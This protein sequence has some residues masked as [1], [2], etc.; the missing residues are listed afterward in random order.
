MTT[1]KKQTFSATLVNYLGIVLGFALILFVMPAIFNEEEV[2][3]LRFLID[4]HIIL[5]IVASLGMSNSLVRFYPS[6]L[7]NKNNS[8]SLFFSAFLI[9]LVGFIIT[10]LLFVLGQKQIVAFF[11][12]KSPALI[13]YSWF[14]LPMIFASMYFLLF[15]SILSIY[16]KVFIPK[17]LK[18]FVIRFLTLFLY[19]LYHW[20]LLT[21]K[22]SVYGLVIVYFI[23]LLFIA[24][25]SI[26]K[27]PFSF[28]NNFNF[29]KT[30]PKIFKEFFSFSFFITMGGIGGLIYAK[31]DLFMLAGYLGLD[32]V[33]IYGIAFYA[34]TII[35]IPKR[36]ITQSI[37]PSLSQF[38]NSHDIKSLSNA[39]KRVSNI[40]FSLGLIL[41]LGLVINIDNLYAIMPKGEIYVLG[42]SVVLVIAFTKAIE[43][44]FGSSLSIM[45]YSKYY[46]LTFY[47]SIVI[48]L[49]GIFL[50]FLFIPK[51]GLLGA[52]LSTASIIILQ[53][54]IFYFTILFKLKFHP[55]SMPLLWLSLIFIG[56]LSLNYLLPPFS[57]PWLDASVRSIVFPGLFLS[58]VL[59]FKLSP[60]IQKLLTD[61]WNRVKA[62]NFKTH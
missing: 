35:E 44:L 16:K 18:E 9:A 40:Q 55:F 48:A 38:I 3:I 11:T 23:T 1:L 25:Y 52:A 20:G 8:F 32:E 58:L 36:I 22:E 62:G 59:Y 60:D 54:I 13:E 42:R 4:I 17:L 33:G 50:N 19:L 47:I 41:L 29:F 30:N 7:G 12:E 37:S 45:L 43:M 61:I 24:L 10:S 26:F 6:S 49:I 53:E 57:N 31:I 15:E 2:G 14:L 39:H 56:V 46:K 34:A 27:S 51:F 5:A 21:F 28:T